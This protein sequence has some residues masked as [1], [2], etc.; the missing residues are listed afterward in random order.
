MSPALADWYQ[1][2]LRL[3]VQGGALFYRFQA[4]PGKPT[5]LLVHGF[6]S[7]GFDWQPLWAGLG[8]HF[9]LLAPDLLGFGFSAKPR[10]F[11]YSIHAQADLLEQLL[12]HLDIGDYHLLAHDYGDTVAQELLARQSAAGRRILSVCLLNGGLFPET[13]RPV[14]IQRLLISPLGPLLAP[15][16]GQRLFTRNLQKVCCGH[17]SEQVL[18]DL[19]CLYRHNRGDRVMAQ[20]I[21]YMRER[22]QHR[23]RWVG[24]LQGAGMPIR[25]INGSEDPVSGRHMVARYRQLVAGADVIELP[26]IGHYPQLEAPQRVLQAYLGF[27]CAF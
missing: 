7:A 26:G 14:L 3:P 15:L 21:R 9:Q 23:A 12:A 19:W 24:A 8:E 18:D 13:H 10:D 5:L 25:L 2:G 11:A 4:N 16:S 6:P 20:L 1:H 27:G 22:R 17:L